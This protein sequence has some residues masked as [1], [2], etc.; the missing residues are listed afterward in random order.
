METHNVLVHKGNNYKPFKCSF[1]NAKFSRLGSLDGHVTR[2]HE[3]KKPSNCSRSDKTKKIVKNSK[4]KLIVSKSEKSVRIKNIEDEIA[5]LRRD[6]DDLKESENDY[7]S[8]FDFDHSLM[9]NPWQVESMD[10]FACLKCPE[11]VFTTKE[12]N[13]F[14]DH[15]VENHPLSH[16]L[17]GIPMQATPIQVMPLQATPTQATPTQATP[18]QAKPTQGNGNKQYPC[19]RCDHTFEKEISLLE[20]LHSV[21]FKTKNYFCHICSQIPQGFSV[22]NDFKKHLSLSHNMIDDKQTDQIKIVEDSEKRTPKT[23]S[24]DNI[25]VYNYDPND[26]VKDYTKENVIWPNSLVR[27]PPW[28]YASSVKN[29]ENVNVLQC[30]PSNSNEVSMITEEISKKTYCVEL[31]LDGTEFEFDNH[32]IN[33]DEE[34]IFEEKN[35][36]APKKVSEMEI[37]TNDKTHND[38]NFIE[39]CSIENFAPT[40][41]FNKDVTANSVESIDNQIMFDKQEFTESQDNEF[42]IEA[43]KFVKDMMCLICGLEFDT[44]VASINHVKKEHKIVDKVKDIDQNCIGHHSQE[45]FAP[46]SNVLK[47]TTGT[48]ANT[49]EANDEQT[50]FNKQEFKVKKWLPCPLCNESFRSQNALNVHLTRVHGE[51]RFKCHYCGDRFTRKDNFKHHMKFKCKGKIYVKLEDWQIDKMTEELR[52][53][54]ESWRM[55]ADISPSNTAPMK[56]ARFEEFRKWT[57]KLKP[58]EGK[59]LTQFAT[60]QVVRKRIYNWI[61]KCK[62]RQKQIGDSKIPLAKWQGSWEILYDLIIL[63]KLPDGSAYN[64]A[65]NTLQIEKKRKRMLNR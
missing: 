36:L 65:L 46:L 54:L 62:N 55:I 15:A 26:I 39:D 32:V 18:R 6:L 13:I 50:L 48:F 9:D 10:V 25:V 24:D 21:H 12:E 64:P 23:D 17:Y 58:P 11:C 28:L 38:Q 22:W 59:N 44:L 27:R 5:H 52:D 8:D 51:N 34:I 45:S 29:K 60:L 4:Q 14:Q 16:V 33:L 49:V 56:E 2:F 53:G 47:D 57:N 35:P 61:M 3:K 20:H 31:S 1:C 40:S 63:N 19:T 37:H 41:N 43:S 7:D 42:Y 30:S